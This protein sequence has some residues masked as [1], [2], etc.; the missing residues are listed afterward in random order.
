MIERARADVAEPP[1]ARIKR[2]E[3]ELDFGLAEELVPAAATTC[4]RARRAT[5]ARS[6]TSS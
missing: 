6:R 5:A 4:T 3:A 2:I 1:S